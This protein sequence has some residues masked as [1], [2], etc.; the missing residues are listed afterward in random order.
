MRPARICLLFQAKLPPV[1]LN[2]RAKPAMSNDAPQRKIVFARH[3]LLRRV[4]A[5]RSDSS[6][7][8]VVAIAMLA[9]VLVGLMG[10]AI[11]FGLA[12]HR[13]ATLQSAA[14][15][16]ALAG[17]KELSLS[18]SKREN[19]QAVVRSVVSAYVRDNSIGAHVEPNVDTKISGKPLKVEVNVA[20]TTR[21]FFGSLLGIRT[22]ELEARAI[23]QIAGQ[24]NICVLSLEPREP[25]AI[26]LS[27]TAELNGRNCAVFSN[28]RSFSGLVVSGAAR[29]TAS[30]VCSA[31]G[32]VG[33]GNIAPLPYSDCP[34][35]EDPLA[36]RPEPKSSGC[37]YTATVIL[38]QDRKLQPGVYCLGLVIAGFSRV[39]FAPGIYVIK[40]GPMLV[41]LSSQIKGEGVGFFL[42]GASFF[43]F[44]PLTKVELSAPK[45]GPM[46]GLLFF[47]S[48]SQSKLL[49]NTILSSNAQKMLGTLYLPNTSLVVESLAR[50]GGESAYTAIVARRLVLLD[51]PHL[52]LNSNYGDTDVPVPAGI[53]GAGQPVMLVK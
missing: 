3:A 48:R 42:Q 17:A 14:D 36:G 51:N 53:K 21:S 23:A 32:V 41:T 2:V 38:N 34:Q 19:V 28:S 22:F 12:T 16:A 27:L 20:A 7:A 35:F 31:G 43:T 6:G 13:R 45:D 50:V 29:M 10:L 40:N 26:S 18:D 9:P 44:D 4:A 37:D 5:I 39:T 24:P 46:A 47:G 25:A 30:T 1:H 49:I 33:N 8:F 15:A 11:D 52:V